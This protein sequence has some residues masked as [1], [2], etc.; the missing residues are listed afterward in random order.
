MPHL[1]RSILIQAPVERVYAL[2]R[3]PK[4][5]T[6]W[7]LGLGPPE[8]LIGAG[9]VGTIVKYSYLMLGIHFPVTMR[10]LED[11]VGPEGAQWKGVIEGPLAGEQTWTYTPQEGGTEVRVDMQYTVPEQVV[12]AIVDRLIIEHLQERS[13]DQTL[14]N[15]KLMCEGSV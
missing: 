10:V 9:E 12:S 2:A 8:K 1:K 6:T 11:R 13:L 3:D 15:L 14:V 5:W 7:Y 4:R